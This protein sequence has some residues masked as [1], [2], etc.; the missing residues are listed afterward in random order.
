M[1][2]KCSIVFGN[3]TEVDQTTSCPCTFDTGTYPLQ[4]IPYQ[5]CQSKHPQNKPT[6][7]AVEQAMENPNILDN[8][9]VV[10]QHVECEGKL[11][12]KLCGP[13]Y[14]QMLSQSALVSDTK[15]SYL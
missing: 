4:Y 13:L 9:K 14:G 5:L 11:D 6:I 2:S 3:S 15:M 1:C 10:L 8:V 12:R 7:L